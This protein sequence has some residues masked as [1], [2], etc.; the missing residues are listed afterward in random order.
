L[1]FCICVVSLR[2]QSTETSPG[3]DVLA[4]LA[5]IQELAAAKGSAW[6][7]PQGDEAL[8]TSDAASGRVLS[9]PELSIRGFGEVGYSRHSSRGTSGTSF[10]L[11]QV[12]LFVTSQLTDRL[13][14]LMET[15]LETSE[16][17][18]KAPC[19][20]LTRVV[21]VDNKLPGQAGYILQ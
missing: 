8:A 14:L 1:F 7:V 4:D 20:D 9:N 21:P 6:E 3:K 16:D 10:D 19:K 12:D 18:L 13:G 17:V 2:A 5:K 11:S 15:V